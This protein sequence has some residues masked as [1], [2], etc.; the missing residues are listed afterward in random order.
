MF[1]NSKLSLFIYLILIISLLLMGYVTVTEKAIDEELVI[2][3][4]NKWNA[5]YN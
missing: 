2:S 3:Q 1:K 4:I 5:A